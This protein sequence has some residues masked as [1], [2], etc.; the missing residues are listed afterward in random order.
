M[1]NGGSDCCGT[2]WF[3]R[4]NGS[5]AGFGVSDLAG[6]AYCEIRELEIP[7]PFWTYCANH[8]HRAPDRDPIPVGPVTQHVSDFEP[9][10]VWKP[11]PDTEEIRDHLL[12]LLVAIQEQ[13]DA[14]YPLGDYRDEVIVWQL[15]ELREPRALDLLERL[16]AFDPDATAGYPFWRRR[17]GLI[18]AAREAVAKIRGEEGS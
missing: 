1:P 16:L 10:F 11:S 17:E 13:P 4:K 8:P 7:V 15:G 12:K 3:N 2:C 9:R 14:E 6:E 5:K 18:A